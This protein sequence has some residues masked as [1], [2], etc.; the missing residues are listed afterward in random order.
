[1]ILIDSSGWLEF[2]T[3]G[4]LASLFAP[5][6]KDLKKI[7]T[8]TILFYEVY[9]TVKRQTTEEL[10]TVVVSQM[11]KTRVLPLTDIT[12]FK[13]ADVSLQ[14]GLSMADSIIYASALLENADLVTSD[15]DLATLPHVIYYKKY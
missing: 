8:P 6:F 9:K 1:M 7:V 2:F 3:E 12:T 10:A 4:K 13:A 14:H 15:S 11:A 5:H